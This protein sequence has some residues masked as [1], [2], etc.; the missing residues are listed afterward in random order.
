MRRT[1]TAGYHHATPLIATPFQP[2]RSGRFA[3]SPSLTQRPGQPAVNGGWLNAHLW[4]K[5]N[6]GKPSRRHLAS[7]LRSTAFSGRARG[8]STS[9]RANAPHDSSTPQ[10]SSQ[11]PMPMP[12]SESQPHVAVQ[13]KEGIRR[14]KEQQ[15]STRPQTRAVRV[16][17]ALA[18]T[19]QCQRA[20]N[21]PVVGG[22]NRAQHSHGWLNSCR[23]R[24][25]GRRLGKVLIRGYRH[26]GGNPSTV[27]GFAGKVGISTSDLLLM[28]AGL[29]R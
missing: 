13:A 19:Q 14:G 20:G 4:V 21:A 15:Q 2:I 6:T 23:G 9:T 1:L 17:T 26:R 25:S 22:V 11:K 10:W 12:T 28:E 24:T 5:V 29:E 18:R 27:G 8:K 7:S 16:R 3:H